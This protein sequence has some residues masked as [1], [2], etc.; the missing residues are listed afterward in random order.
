MDS[1]GSFSLDFWNAQFFQKQWGPY[2]NCLFWKAST[3]PILIVEKKLY[4]V[5]ISILVSINNCLN[6]QVIIYLV[7]K[8]EQLFPFFFLRQCW[9]L[10][11][12]KQTN[13]SDEILMLLLMLQKSGYICIYNHLECENTPSIMRY[14]FPS[15]GYIARF[16]TNHQQYHYGQ[17]T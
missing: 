11:V 4:S 13:D 5:P 6:L 15:T 8:F 17:S 3:Q 1:E 10:A 16:G 7:S 2:V 12:N 9:R 14:T